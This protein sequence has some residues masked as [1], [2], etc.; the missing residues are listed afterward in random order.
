M[1]AMT[2]TVTLVLK[3][4]FSEAAAPILLSS[5]LTPIGRNTPQ[6]ENLRAEYLLGLEVRHARIIQEEGPP[7][8]LDLSESGT[9]M[10]DGKPVGNGPVAIKEGDVLKFGEQLEYRVEQMQEDHLQATELML[11][12]GPKLQLL[13]TP[14]SGQG[15]GGPIAVTEFPFLVAKSDGH[16]ASYQKCLPKIVAFLSRRHAHFYENNGELLLEDLGS[17]NGTQVNGERL[18]EQAITL[19][20]GDEVRFGHKGFT[21]EVTL[22]AEEDDIT[23]RPLPEGTVMISSAGSF[24]DVYCDES[25]DEVADLSLADTDEPSLAPA[26]LLASTNLSN[27][28]REARIRWLQWPYLGARQIV[29]FI[30]VPVLILTAL[31]VA[32]TRD[33]RLEEV[34]ELLDLAQPKA[35]LAVAVDYA[36]ENPNDIRVRQLLET[37]FE[38][39]VLPGWID[40]MHSNGPPAALSF[41]DTHL[42]LAPMMADTRSS[43]LLRWMSELAQFVAQS[44]GGISVSVANDNAQLQQLAK[45]WR[46]DADH[47]TRLLRRFSDSYSELGQIHAKAMSSIRA[48]QGEGADQL[49]AVEQLQAKVAEMIAQSQLDAAR[50]FVAQYALDHSELR[51]MDEFSSDLE[52]LALINSARMA[53]DLL[54]FLSSTEEVTFDTTFFRTKITT[55]Q[56]ERRIA[57]GV[58]QQIAQAE[59]LWQGGQLEPAVAALDLNQDSAWIDVVAL[60]KAKYSRLREGFAYLL[61]MVG[62][63][64]YP[65]LVIDFYAQ[66]DETEDSFLRQALADDFTNQRDRALANAQA[67]A[68]QGARSWAKYNQTFQG[69]GGGLRLETEVSDT[70]REFAKQLSAS[71]NLLRRAYRLLQLLEVDIPEALE[72]QTLELDQEVVRQH[73]ALGSLRSVLGRSVV[74]QKLDLLPSVRPRT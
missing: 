53:L 56:Q 60:R 19:C 18:K 40:R 63:S 58:R 39:A 45:Q 1:D 51:G 12:P 6:M 47:Y 46:V 59:S 70:Y 48:I 5:S 28:W 66:L 16:F 33:S 37:S 10:L 27:L 20:D 21:F 61:S 9:T 72:Q 71:A 74:Q 14:L 44:N 2:D 11:Q 41:L 34:R 50:S 32:M 4:M 64:E 31:L 73:N 8:L 69:I 35:A 13:L 25:N 49:K 57:I 17:T 54:N 68:A 24:L 52:K 29:L 3:P 62:T 36:G 55:L 26:G 65:D 67:L 43:S 7:L 15:P 30:V 42:E 23:Q 38:Q 22:I